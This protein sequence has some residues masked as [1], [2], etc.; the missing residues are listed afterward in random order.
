M[1]KR[2]PPARVISRKSVNAAPLRSVDRLPLPVGQKVP[3]PLQTRDKVVSA[4][5]SAVGLGGFTLVESSLGQSPGSGTALPLGD[6]GE[7]YAERNVRRVA[8]GRPVRA[9]IAVLVG[10]GAALGGLDAYVV[11]SVILA[12]P[13]VAAG[14]FVALFLW[15]RYGRSYESEVVAVALLA[16]AAM[17]PGPA[18]GAPPSDLSAVVW[19][20]GRVRS[21]TYAG[22][23]T[24]VA[25]VDCPVSLMEALARMV[26]QF[27][28]EVG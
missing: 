26:H 15:L 23:R 25:V 2:D 16:P 10:A 18:D 21:I 3:V 24:A 4:V 6:A 20:A 17:P 14:V 19:T 13:W 1:A 8:T 27:Q 28:S 7:L 12:A 9:S 11:G 22:A 5:S